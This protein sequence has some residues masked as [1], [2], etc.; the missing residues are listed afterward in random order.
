M[1]SF[2]SATPLSAYS[3]ELGT[4]LPRGGQ[5]GTEVEF[6]FH[7]KQLIEPQ[8]II[9]YKP[10]VS[11]K[12][13]H[14]VKDSHVKA[15]LAIAPDAELGEHPVRLRCKGGVTYMRTFWVGQ[16]ATVNEAEPN[17]DF[18]KPQ[19]VGFNT[20]VHGTAGLEDADYYGV[21]VKKGQRISAE[22]EGMRLGAVFFD[23][24]LA[25]LDSRRFE[26]ATSDDAP[27]LRQDAFVSVV[28]PEDGEYTVLVRES[29]YEGNDNCRYRLHIGGFSRPSAVYP[30]AAHPGVATTFR[31]IGDPAGDYAF[32]ATPAG[33]EGSVHGLFAERD[34]LSSPS[35]NPVLL[36]ALPFANESEPN[37][38]SRQ[39]TPEPPLDAPCAFHGIISKTG[40]VDWFRFHAR[41]GQDLRIR[42]RGRSLRSPLDSVLILRDSKGKQINRNDDQGSLDSI[43]DF[44]PPADADYFVNVR[45]HLGKGGSDYTY[46]VEIDKREPTLS[47]SLPVGLRNDSQYRK[48]IC[49]P[50]GNRYATVVNVTRQNVA[51]D[52]KLQADSLPQGVVMQHSAAPSNA[53]SFLALFEAAP[54]APIAGGLHHFSILDASP[55]SRV[56]GDLEE[57]IHH[58]EINN[59]GTFHSTYDDRITVAVIEEAPF[60]VDLF[61]PPVPI[62]QNGTARLKVTLRRAP[63]FDGAVKVTLPWKPPGIGSPTEITIPKGENEAFYNIN[64]SADAAVGNH[65]VCVV[66]E[67][68]TPKGLVMV[69][70][71]LANLTVSE[72]F[73]TVT[74]EMA[75]TI[76]GENT[77]L[78]C[79]VNHHQPIQGR[80]QMILH[81]LPHGVKAAP[82][83][84]DANTKEVIFD[85]EVA[86]DATKGKHNALFCQILPRKKG[87]LIP[88]NTGH[89][90]TLRINPPPPAPKVAKNGPAKPAVA[91]TA[92][93]AAPPKPSKPLSR[94]EQLRQRKKQ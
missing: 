70:S 60:H 73:M 79:K 35:P 8:E 24:Y 86:K 77:V 53:N 56:R 81:G 25:I 78:L 59:T 64:A 30:P 92:P 48:V 18:S 11:V 22:V 63:G 5:R 91:K 10:G 26:L 16:F 37:N 32:Q 2:F 6:N 85:L 14:K 51:C 61:V 75:S 27:L 7:G 68:T 54:D 65:Q 3:P 15:V 55:G 39:A 90:G 33:K 19:R 40:D 66:A 1:V 72:P 46:R 12:S 31:M 82:R 94:L 89:G 38:E 13:L 23:P 28:A 87:Y 52:C 50:R 21:T 29:S 69:S 57:M 88:H 41:K 44:K 83:E 9:F 34:G 42:V 80:A 93:K 84:I 74:M 67:S 17:N 49:V 20:T 62:V 4:I 71:A 47:A 58:V 76:P 43:I 45:D 36:S